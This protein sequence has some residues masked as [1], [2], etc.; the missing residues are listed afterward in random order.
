VADRGGI[1]ALHRPIAKDRNLKPGP[2]QNPGWHFS[3][4]IRKSTPR[5][6]VRPEGDCRSFEKVTSFDVHGEF[7]L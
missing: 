1:G 2:A 3:G 6:E 7:P 5:D 4:L